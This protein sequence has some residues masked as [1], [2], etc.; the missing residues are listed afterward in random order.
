MRVGEHL[1]F[2][3]ARRGDVFFDQHPS[4]AERSLSLADGALERSVEFDMRVDAAH[5]AAAPARDRLDEHR[6]ADFI[7]LFA[8]EFRVLVVAVIAGHDRH[9]GPLHQRLGRAFQAHRPHRSGRRADKND[10]RLRAG[11]REISVL[12]QESVAR[13]QTFGAD[14]LRQRD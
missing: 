10:A 8:Q 3:V 5:S 9:A 12:G 4:V 6:I 7:G 1:Q 2:D 13:M 11:F 14:C